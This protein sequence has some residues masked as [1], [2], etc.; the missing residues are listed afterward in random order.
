ME[1]AGQMIAVSRNGDVVF[2][3]GL[4]QGRLGAGTGAVDFIGHQKLGEDRPFDK[5]KMTLALGVL[6]QNFAAQNIGGHQIRCKLDTLRLQ[7]HHMSQSFDKARFGKAGHTDDEAMT[8]RKQGDE[9]LFDHAFLTKNLMPDG[10]FDRH[11]M[12]DGVLDLDRANALIMGV[13]GRMC[14]HLKKGL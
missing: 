5:A 8:A 12:C 1:G 2:L 13:I 6:V 14:V 7:P 4:Q 3:H 11:Q 9:R 10:L